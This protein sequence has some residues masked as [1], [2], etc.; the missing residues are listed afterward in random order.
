V[1][2]LSILLLFLTCIGLCSTGQGAPKKNSVKKRIIVV[3][4]YHTDYAWSQDTNQ[5]FCASMLKYGYFEDRAQADEYTRNDYV[6]TAK[7]VVKKMWMDAKRNTGKGDHVRSAMEITHIIKA[8]R[9]DLIFLGDDEAG[10]YIGNQFL[11]TGVPMVFWGFNDNP[12]KYGLVESAERPG[13][14]VTGV[15]QSG[16]FRESLQLLKKL[17]PKARTFAILSD[18][19][20]SGRADQKGIEFLARSG[21]LPLRLIDSVVTNDFM[22]WKKRALDLQEKVDAFFVAQYSTLKDER[23]VNVP[24]LAVARWYIENI[25]IPE[26]AFGIFVKQGLLCSADDSGYK[27]AFEAVAVAHDILA[28]GAVP[29][30]TPTRTPG[31]GALRVNRERARMLGITLNAAMGIEEYYDG[32]EPP[33]DV[34]QRGGKE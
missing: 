32:A 31:R 5:G 10:N 9:P 21:A 1:K 2:K 3:S 16:H 6:E 33:H 23:G 20:P 13:H 26:A 12:V 19:S 18:D 24:N 15:Y 27:Q 11:D 22:K 25:H 4:S 14:N 7:V 17:A 8:F 28:K 29:A 30:I 34:N